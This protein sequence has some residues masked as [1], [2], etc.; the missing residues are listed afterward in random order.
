MLSEQALVALG[1]ADG[2]DLVDVYR[3]SY[4]DSLIPTVNWRFLTG[5]LQAS[6]GFLDTAVEP[7]RMGP[8][9]RSPK[10]IAMAFVGYFFPAGDSMISTF[11]RSMA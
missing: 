6:G 5:N 10:L 11:R 3:R 8:I 1:L 9:L 7:P 4:Y 2:L